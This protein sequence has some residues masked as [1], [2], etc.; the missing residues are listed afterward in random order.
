[1]RPDAK[2]RARAYIAK[3]A[4]RAVSGQ[5][6]DNTTH[7]VACTL[8][9]DFGLSDPD[10]AELLQDYNRTKC[11]PPW[12]ER[13]LER[14]VRS[15]RRTAN[16]KPGEVGKLLGVDREDYTGPKASSPANNAAAAKPAAARAAA[17]PR[18]GAPPPDSAS[19]SQRTARTPLFSVRRAGEGA[20]P[21]TART[22][23]T[24]A[25]HSFP[26]PS[27][28]SPAR[29]EESKKE[30]SEKSE[31]ATPAAAASSPSEASAPMLRANPPASVQSSK[32]GLRGDVL[33][34]YDA[35]L[36][37]GP[38]T[39]EYMITGLK[40]TAER[41]SAAEAWLV[42]GGWIVVTTPSKGGREP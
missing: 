11:D 19:A 35:L 29:L 15:A 24:L 21:R 1:M 39:R 23:R 26:I 36:R 22:V 12:S 4:P 38:M 5:G 10:V 27:P 34:V 30:M 40:W 28:T 14:H 32:E 25:I 18:A 13:D 16:S 33:R 42:T 9:V 17:P 3:S 20:E 8:S 2:E 31:P 41:F 37:R 7:A 6:G